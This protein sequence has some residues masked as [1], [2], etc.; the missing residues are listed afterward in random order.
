MTDFHFCVEYPVSSHKSLTDVYF[1]RRLFKCIDAFHRIILHPQRRITI[2]YAPCKSTVPS[3]L[4][5]YPH[6]QWRTHANKWIGD[7]FFIFYQQN[8]K[9]FF[10]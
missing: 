10:F 8:K 9:K 2:L 5:F 4:M 1:F 7:A 3:C 6:P